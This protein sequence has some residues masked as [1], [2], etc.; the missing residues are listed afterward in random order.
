MPIKYQ[1]FITRQDCRNNPNVIYVF[2]DNDQREGYGGQAKEMRG[3]VNTVGIRVKKSPSGIFGA[4]YTDKEYVENIMKIDEDIDKIV[5]YLEEGITV[6]IPSDGIGTGL[7]KLQQK[8]PKTFNYLI[9]IL[10]LLN[11]YGEE[12]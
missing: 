12:E 7:A 1:K 2:G 4:Y 5:S 8:A 3:W 11:V 10:Y 6:V 9:N